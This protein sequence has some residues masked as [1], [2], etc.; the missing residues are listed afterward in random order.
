M[1]FVNLHVHSHFSLL[2]GMNRIPE[3]VRRAQELG[4][5]ALAITD[6]GSLAGIVRFY[7]TCKAYGIRP[8]LGMEAYVVPDRRVKEGK[9]GDYAHLILLAQDNTGLANLI[10]IS[11][12]AHLEG[13]YYKPRTDRAFLAEH[14]EGLIVTSACIAGEIAQAIL[15]GDMDTAEQ[16]ALA[17]REVFGD[18]YYLEIQSSTFEQQKQ[19]NQAVVELAKRLQIPFVVTG[20]CHYLRPEDADPHDLLLAIQTASRKDDPKRLRLPASDYWLKSEDDTLRYLLESG[21]ERADAV[22]AI[23]TTFE[24]AGR[25]HVELPLYESTG[26]LRYPQ[27]P[28]TAPDGRTRYVRPGESPEL[29][30]RR[31]SR[32]ALRRMVLE[33]GRIPQSALGAY[34][35]RLEYELHV[36]E[37]AG[38]AGYFLVEKAIVDYCRHRGIACQARGS[39][40]GSLVAYVLG[41]TST[42]PIRH[43]LSFERF[44]VPGRKGRPDIDL[45]VDASR[46]QEVLD[47]MVQRFGHDRVALIAAYASLNPRALV[48]DVGRSLGYPYLQVDRL[49]KELPQSWTDEESGEKVQATF[50]RLYEDHPHIRALRE[51]EENRPIFEYAEKLEGLARHASIHAGGV[52]VAPHSLYGSLPLMRPPGQQETTRLAVSQLD[53]ED[54]EALG[55]LKFDVLGVDALTVRE[56]TLASIRARTGS[57]PDL[58]RL[59]LDDPEVYAFLRSGHTYGVFQVGT[60]PGRRALSIIQPENFDELVDLLSLMRPGPANNGF[61]ELYARYKSGREVPEYLHPEMARILGSTKGVMVYQEQILD[62]VRTFA[63]FS[64]AEADDVRRAI[65]KKHHEKLA[66]IGPEFVRRSVERGMLT[67]EVAQELWMQILKFGSYTFNAAHA[68]SY[69]YLAYQTAWLKRYYPADFLAAVLANEASASGEDRDARLQE[70]YRECRRLGITILGPDIN[71]SKLHATA[72]DE[73]TIRLGFSEVRFLDKVAA[74]I[75]EKQPYRDLDDFLSRHHARVANKKVVA[76]LICVGAFD[77]VMPTLD[78]LSILRTYERYR[79]RNCRTMIQYKKAAIGEVMQ[80]SRTH[81]LVIP[82]RP[83]AYESYKLMWETT[84]LSFPVSTHPA[85]HLPGEEFTPKSR[86]EEVAVAGLV[87]RVSVR[88]TQKGPTPGAEMALVDLDLPEGRMIKAILFPEVYAKVKGTPLYPQAMKLFFGQGVKKNSEE[89]VIKKVLPVPAPPAGTDEAIAQDIRSTQDPF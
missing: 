27:P 28:A 40:G 69:A 65:G 41:I 62:I 60:G 52:I 89:L 12:D 57:A 74:A 14:S 61:P 10:R 4:Q 23:D 13:F 84:L 21:V 15:T 79:T 54:V 24:L 47:W 1:G 38:L 39:A 29:A 88:R 70:A 68:C 11:T 42:D 2:D 78:R 45:D 77:S 30:L 64:H 22:R 17:Y 72:V 26:V 31:M 37:Q 8:I 53:M 86:R 16:I 83:R 18:R 59:S 34:S 75:V 58:S 73:R 7:Q 20:D 85:G 6:H 19:V 56:R 44:Y 33:E 3:V 43:R 82:D 25:V 48:R 71:E 49:S 32:T 87:V 36:L 66:A 67:E 5:Q 46:R 55:Y 76:V 50:A 35:D 80:L 9:M 63:G 51:Q 81:R